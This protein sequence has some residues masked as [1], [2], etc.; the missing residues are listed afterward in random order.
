M[1]DPGSECS[2]EGLAWFARTVGWGGRVFVGF[3]VLLCVLASLARAAGAAVPGTISTVA[4]NGTE[5]F[6]GDGGPAFLAAMGQPGGVA[7]DPGGDLL[8]VD[9][10]NNRVRLVSGA[11]C[12]SDCP[13]GLPSTTEGDIYTVA[14]NGTAGYSGDSGPAT[15]AGLRY[16]IAVAVDEYGDLVIA[17]SSSR[18][19]LV[20]K[21]S[22]ASDCPYGLAS[23]ARGDIY[24]VAGDGVLGYSGDGGAATSAEINFPLGVAVD[25]HG[26]LAI[27]DSYNYRVR[28]V[29][30]S[31]CASD[32]PYGLPSLTK[33]YIYTV[34]GNGTA[35]Y[36]G[37]D[38]PATRA[39]LWTP[40]GLTFDGV[41]DLL[42]ADMSNQRVRL[43]AGSSCAFDCQY[44]LRSMTPGDIYTVAGDGSDGYSGDGSPANL[45]KLSYPSGVA[46][47]EVGDLL[48]DE[49]NNDRV[50]LVPDIGCHIECA[51]GLPS[52]WEGKGFIYTVA[53]NG[54]FGYGGDGGPAAIAELGYPFA[55]GVDDT[56]DLLI[57]DNYNFRIRLVTAAQPPPVCYETGARRVGQD[58]FT[59]QRDQEDVIVYAPTGLA[60]ITGVTLV[61]GTA[62]YP[63]FTP[64]TT[65]PVL[66]TATKTV[67]STL[68]SGHYKATDDRGRTTYCGFYIP[69][70][71]AISG[72]NPNGGSTA[73]GNTVTLTGT[74]FYSRA[75]VKFGT[76]SAT[77]VVI[78][79]P[80]K[81]TVTAPAHTAGV[82]DVTVTTP[83]GT[84]P[85]TSAD[86]YSYR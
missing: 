32:C 4:G 28:L 36:G 24:T 56:G 63:P 46:V 18:V 82:V 9:V 26:N 34:A 59:G 7:A 3:V 64:G 74:G 68:T 60:S 57:G 17:D 25:Q 8:I 42:I 71:P 37:D 55:I 14:G 61:N 22:C 40:R 51:Y 15:S 41:G 39:E 33:G 1:L 19:R 72:V 21:A 70:V 85:T 78:V 67:Q 54:T 73:G 53:G 27:S 31:N 52:G 45:A 35:G 69:P 48:V 86:R 66:V 77:S 43:V 76:V 84:S 5:G 62:T 81:I 38:G 23:M 30:A 65:G 6:S 13:Y 10:S 16:P 49:I 2:P 12:A 44:G 79:S 80:T 75:T 83:G 50:R 47:D 58:G 29:A 20:A 11:S